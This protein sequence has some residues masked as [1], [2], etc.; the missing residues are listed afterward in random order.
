MA[1]SR[2]TVPSLLD[3][4]KNAKKGKLLPLYYL[5]GEDTY[6]LSLG[7]K[8]IEDAVAPFIISDFDIDI[9]YSDARDLQGVLNEAR[10]FPFGSQKKLI[11]YKEAEKVKDKKLLEAYILSPPDFTLL[12]LVHNGKISSLTSSP[13][14]LLLENNFL[15]EARE[16]KGENMIEWVKELVTSKERKISNDNAVL[17]ANISGENRLIIESQLEKIITYLGDK[18]EITFNAINEVTASFKEYTVFDL[19]NA[20]FQKNKSAA[21]KIAFGLLEKNPEP[22]LI[23]NML[24]KSFI[25][26]SQIRELNEKKIP[27]TE[28]AKIVGTHPFYLKNFQR[29]SVLFTNNDLIKATEALLKADVS[30]KTTSTDTKTVIALLIA[31]IF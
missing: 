2:K 6:S 5:F 7:V 25:G 31:E 28:A 20:V 24:T 1:Q 8:A 26:L 21:L 18:T 16:L 30:I 27:E 11:I 10:A 29:A 9:C 4:V 15:Y 23:I 13:F 22:T 17:L 3:A 19:Q 12:V 14:N